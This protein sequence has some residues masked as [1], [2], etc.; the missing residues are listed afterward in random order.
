VG[1]GDPRR[2][3]QAGKLRAEDDPCCW[4]SPTPQ[5]SWL[6]SRSRAVEKALTSQ[7][8]GETE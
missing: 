4:P 7:M 3:D 6:A 5:A 8:F 2:A 1:P